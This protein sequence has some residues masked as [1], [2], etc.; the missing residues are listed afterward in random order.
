MSTTADEYKFTTLSVNSPKPYVLH[1]QLDR[2]EKHNTMNHAMWKDMTDCFSKASD[3]ENVRSIVLSGKGRL[4]TAGL[5]LME[6]AQNFSSSP[7]QD[8]ARRGFKMAKY[9]G[10]AQESCSAIERCMKPVVVAIHGACIGGGMDVITACDIRLCAE[11]AYFSIKEVDVGLA[12]DMGTLQRLPKIIGNDSL[13]RELS[14]TARKIGS[15]EALSCGLVSKVYKDDK[16]LMENALQLAAFI[17][18]KSPVA[19]QSTKVNLNYAR[20][21]SIPEGLEFMKSWN[22]TMLQT[23]DI[24]KSAGAFMQKKTPADVEFSKL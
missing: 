4:F 1:I 17:A 5:D 2:E 19:V 10:L 22:A 23:E 11:N 16:E 24:M 7:D 3:D 18:T 9:I 13:V 6:A 15:N 14:Y 12:A 8:V 21:H 20:N